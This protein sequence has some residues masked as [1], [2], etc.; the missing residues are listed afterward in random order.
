MNEQIIQ[1]K[2][3]SGIFQHFDLCLQK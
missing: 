2:G 1:E 3:T